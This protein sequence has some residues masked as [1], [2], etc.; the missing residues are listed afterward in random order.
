MTIDI[1]KPIY[2]KIEID[3]INQ[4]FFFEGDMRSCVQQAIQLMLRPEI[5][6]KKR[7][8]QPK[9]RWVWS[10][11]QFTSVEKNQESMFNKSTEIMGGLDLTNVEI[12]SDSD[13][14]DLRDPW[15][16]DE[17]ILRLIQINTMKDAFEKSTP[18]ERAEL[19]QY[20]NQIWPEFMQ[21]FE[22]KHLA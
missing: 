17:R 8:G 11:N 19:I 9:M 20:A 12:I 1:T 22:R 2:L 3:G 15:L 4:T 21:S 10:R 18:S 6:W 7:D 13:L 14:N 16:S 5:C